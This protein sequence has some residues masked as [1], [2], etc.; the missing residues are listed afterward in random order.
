MHRPG[1]P[2]KPDPSC[3]NRTTNNTISTT[4]SSSSIATSIIKCSTIITSTVKSST[5]IG[6][7]SETFLEAFALARMAPEICG[8]GRTSGTTSMADGTQEEWGASTW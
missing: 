1:R 7:C 5:N 3:S 4:I 2:G 6:K 8:A